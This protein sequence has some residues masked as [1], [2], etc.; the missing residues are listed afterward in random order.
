MFTTVHHH[1]VPVAVA[2]TLATLLA[3]GAAP[4]SAGKA[5]SG[6]TTTSGGYTLKRLTAPARTLAYD[7]AGKLVATFTDNART[8][9]VVGAS[10]TFAEPANTTATVTTTA[11]VR[12]LSSPFA[13]S[14]DTAWLT[15]RRSDPSPDLLAVAFQYGVGAATLTDG[16]GSRYAG[17]ASYGP[18]QPDGTRAEGSDF[19]DY[20]G[21]AW[22]YGTTADAPETDQIGALDCSGFVRMTFGYRS[23]IPLSLATDGGASLPRRAAWMDAASPGIITIANSGAV[24]TSR[25][26]LQAGDLVFFDASTDDGTAIDHVGIY[27]GRDGAGHDRFLSSRKT[28]DGPTMG[29]LGGKSILDGTGYYATAFRSAR[30]I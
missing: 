7:S 6:G 24:P 2:L 20:L 3:T 22:T 30:R 5:P 1:R 4:A 9:V 11:W 19:N 15:A 13:G 17:D 18:L 12:L 10:R 23:G 16:G 21:I 29:D 8:V 25:S 14:V 28:A 26:I 27:L